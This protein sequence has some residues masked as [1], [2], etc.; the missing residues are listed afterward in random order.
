MPFKPVNIKDYLDI[1]VNIPIPSSINI[2][3]ISFFASDK[4]G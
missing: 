1:R 4:K 3:S 2:K